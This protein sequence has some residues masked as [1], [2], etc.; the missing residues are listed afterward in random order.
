MARQTR[1][2]RHGAGSAFGE[3]ILAD[4]GTALFSTFVLS[5][6]D[7]DEVRRAEAAEGLALQA[8]RIDLK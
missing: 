8:Q 4:T 3:S 5:A 1:P 2:Q 7:N 6:V